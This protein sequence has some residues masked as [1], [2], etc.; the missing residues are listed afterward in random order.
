MLL[1]RF[2][3]N[4]PSIDFD[5]KKSKD[6]VSFNYPTTVEGGFLLILTFG[7]LLVNGGTNQQTKK[8]TNLILEFTCVKRTKIQ[9]EGYLLLILAIAYL[10]QQ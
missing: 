2:C 3:V 5:V 10:T 9:K 4:L 7:C 6:Q 8:F 1:T